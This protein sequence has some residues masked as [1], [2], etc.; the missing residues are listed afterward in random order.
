MRSI[1]PQNTSDLLR[2]LIVIATISMLVIIVFSTFGFY[3]IFNNF[4]ISNAEEQSVELCQVMIAE[5]RQF[6]FQS[7][8]SSN[9][10]EPMDA[11]T[12]QQIDQALRRFLKPF[13]IVKI[14][15][16]NDKRTIVYS[17]DS[18]IIG[19]Q[20]SD[21]RRLDNAMAGN[22]DSKLETKDKIR[23]LSEEEIIGLEVVETYVPIMGQ[24][25]KLQGCF[26]IYMNVNKFQVQAWRGVLVAM[27]ILIVVVISVFGSMF[28]LIKIGT[29]R[30]RMFQEDLEK[31]AVTDMLTGLSNRG[32]L[33]GRGQEQFARVKRNRLKGLANS[34]L[35]G[36]MIDI[37]FFKSINDSKG[38][39]VGDQVLKVVAERIRGCLRTYDILGRYGGEEFVALLPDTDFETSRIVAER[40]WGTIR[41]DALPVNDDEL[42][43]TVSIGIANYHDSDVELDDILKRADDALYKAKHGGRDRIEWLSLEVERAV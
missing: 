13:Q 6:F 27:S 9:S 33:I 37:D 12:Y 40:I 15:V 18:R 22:V 14:K 19:M 36:L 26:E 21:N 17:T 25:G 29:D 23:D 30:L 39:L 4:V 11:Q 42:R 3:R 7:D 32:D 31:M 8:R 38:H 1:E 2:L 16:Y 20:D 24:S 41:N 28:F 34:S 10:N 5:Y 43:L 35:G